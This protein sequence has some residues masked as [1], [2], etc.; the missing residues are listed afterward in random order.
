[1]PK[2]NLPT[3]PKKNP[4]KHQNQN[5]KYAF[6]QKEGD[7]FTCIKLLQPPYK[8][9]I[10][11][12]GKVGFAKEEDDKG[13]LP[14][15]FDYDIIFNPHEETSIDKQEFIDYIGDILV[16]LLDKQIK[17]GQAIYE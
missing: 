14:M 12:Y 8:G 1:M 10:Y 15:Q 2:E 9:I 4:K 5:S 3:E 13:N 11:K 16:E 7:D 17:G 6:V